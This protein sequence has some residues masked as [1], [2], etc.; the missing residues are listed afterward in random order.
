MSVS[1]TRASGSVGVGLS[2][3]TR[4]AFDG[5]SSE[6][7][8][9][10]VTVSD[11]NV[12]VVTASP[13]YPGDAGVS[14]VQ[15]LAN[16]L[17]GANPGSSYSF[18]VNSA[19]ELEVQ[20][21]GAATSVISI[22]AR[23]TTT[24][25][26]G[27]SY[28]S[29]VEATTLSLTGPANTGDQWSLYLDTAATH[30]TTA[31]SLASIRESFIG[32]ANAHANYRAFEGSAEGVLHL[33]RTSGTP[34]VDVAVA[35]GSGHLAGALV[36][37]EP[38]RHWSYVLALQSVGDNAE[39]GPV[40]LS[41]DT[42]TLTYDGASL[43]GAASSEGIDLNEPLQ[44]IVSQFPGG[45]SSRVGDDNLS[46]VVS[47]DAGDAITFGQV[48]QL[49][50]WVEAQSAASRA[51]SLVG[52][53]GPFYLTAAF[54]LEG[55]VSPGEPWQLEIDGTSY[56]YSIAVGGSLSGDYT[57]ENIARGLANRIN[58]DSASPYTASAVGIEIR[59]NSA[60]DINYPNLNPFQ[61]N[62]ERGDGTSR[63]VFDLD[64]VNQVRGGI[65]FTVSQ[66][67]DRVEYTAR[68]ELHLFLKNVDG[69]LTSI[70]TE[71]L[72]AGSRDPGSLNAEDPIFAYNFGDDGN[73][74]AGTYILRVSTYRDFDDRSLRGSAAFPFSDGVYNGVEDGMSYDL[75]ISA[76]SH[77]QAS[78]TLDLVGTEL[79]YERADGEV[80]TA[81]I[82]S[83][84]ATN[85]IFVLNDQNGNEPLHDPAAIISAL[86][87]RDEFA[88]FAD[89]LGV[90]PVL[91]DSY[92]MVLTGAPEGDETVTITIDPERTRTL[93]SD[94]AFNAL[95]YFGEQYEEQVEVA[96]TRAVVS[97]LG[98]E[99]FEGSDFDFSTNLTLTLTPRG[100]T[101]PA[102]TVQGESWESFI[103]ALSN[104]SL[105]EEL[106]DQGATVGYFYRTSASAAEI[107]IT[108]SS[109]FFL[110]VESATTEVGTPVSG[111]TVEVELTGQTDLGQI[112]NL[113]LD[114][115]TTLRYEIVNAASAGGPI[116]EWV[117]D[118]AGV[119]SYTATSN[120]NPRITD[121][122]EAF[123]N[124]IDQD[125]DLPYTAER[126]GRILRISPAAS[127]GEVSVALSSSGGSAVAGGEVRP[128]TAEVRHQIEFTAANWNVAQTVWVRAVD[129]EYIDGGDRLV[130]APLEERV[131]SVRGPITVNGGFGGNDERFLTNPVLLE[132][133]TN[134]PVA[135]GLIQTLGREYDA[136]AGIY[137]A[138]IS[139]INATHINPS[140]GLRPGFDPRMN[141]FAY[142]VEF[143]EGVAEGT[144]LEVFSVSQ[145]ILSIG[146]A[147]PFAVDLQLA[148]ISL[149]DE[150]DLLV[151]AANVNTV[152]TNSP[153][154]S[155][156]FYT[157]TGL[158]ENSETWTVT[159]Q[160][161]SGPEQFSVTTVAVDSDDDG[162]PDPFERRII[163]SNLVDGIS[164]LD[165]VTRATDF[166][167]DGLTDLQE[168]LLG[169]DPLV[170]GPVDSDDDGIPDPFEQRI[171]DSNA[172]DGISSLDQVTGAT[173]FDSDG[174]TDLQE[175]R[176]GTDP[177]VED[178]DVVAGEEFVA[179]DSDDDGIPDPFEQRII[180]SNRSDG[181][182]SLDQ[183]TGA[184]D[185]D[186]DGLT[187]LQEYRL[188]TDPLVEDPDSEEDLPLST[189]GRVV[190]DLADQIDSH[191]DFAA[192][193]RIGLLG[194]VTLII[195][196]S[197]DSGESLQVTLDTNSLTAGRLNEVVTQGGFIES[198]G[199]SLG[200]TPWTMAAIFL[201]EIGAVNSSW[202]FSVTGGPIDGTFSHPVDDNES[203]ATVLQGLVRRMESL[204][205]VVDGSTATFA[206]EFRPS[207]TG[208]TVTFSE[209]WVVATETGLTLRPL[210]GEAYYYAPFN[211][212]LAVDELDQV[213]VLNVYNGDSPSDDRAILT[214]NRLTGL[215]MGPDTV[216]AG[217]AFSGGIGFEAMEEVNLDLGSGNDTLTVE[218]TP[219][220]LVT[221]GAGA[222]NDL[223]MLENA[224]ANIQIFGETDDDIILVGS[225]SLDSDGDGLLDAWELSWD[226]ISSLGDLS[227]DG[228]FDGDGSTDLQAFNARLNPT[229]AN[230]SGNV[231][232]MTSIEGLASNIGGGVSVDA[233]EGNDS[234][235]F[236]NS[237]ES[238]QQRGTITENSVSGFGLGS[239]Y[240]E[241]VI[242]THQVFSVDASEGEFSFTL[243]GES[244]VPLSFDASAQDVANAL[245][246]ILNPNNSDNAKPHT[247]NF[248]VEELG[249]EYHI[250]FRGE[251]LGLSINPVDVD[252]SALEGTMNFRVLEPVL[253]YYGVETL[254]LSLGSGDDIV[255]VQGTS[256][257]TNLQLNGG[258]DEI[259][260]SSEFD[261]S[262]E[263]RAVPYIGSLDRLAGALNIDAGEGTHQI[264]ISDAGSLLDDP[265]ILITDILPFRSGPTVNLVGAQA[266]ADMFVLGIAPAPITL[267]TSAAGN[268]DEGIRIET[269]SGDDHVYISSNDWSGAGSGGAEGCSGASAALGADLIT[270]L[271]NDTV[272][273]ELSSDCDEALR[274][275]TQ[276]TFTHRMLVRPEVDLAG[277]TNP[278]D[279][280]GLLVAGERLDQ[281]LYRVNP[282][283]N[284]IDM[285]LGDDVLGTALVTA[286]VRKAT[287]GRLEVA[288]GISN[289]E[290]DYD[291]AQEE[292][293]ALFSSETLLTENVDYFVTGDP[294]EADTIEI[295]FSLRFNL[296]ENTDITWEVSEVLTQAVP[297][298]ALRSADRDQ[299]DA[300]RA[301]MS[302]EIRTGV[303]A[304][305]VKGGAGDDH[306]WTGS[307][308]D[309]VFGGAGSDFIDATDS[310]GGSDDP[311]IVF[312]DG[313]YAQLQTLRLV[314]GVPV[315]EDVV[316][317][318]RIF[319][320][321]ALPIENF[322]FLNRL[323]GHPLEVGGGD[324]ILVG[325]GDNF[326]MG[327]PGNDNIE[328]GDG[329][330]TLIGDTGEVG[331]QNSRILTI[332]SIPS[333][334][335][336]EAN[337]IITAGDGANWILGGL[338]SDTITVG[339]D[340]NFLMGDLGSLFFEFDFAS[341]LNRLTRME[342]RYPSLGAGDSISA[343]SGFNYVVTGVGLDSGVI[344]GSGYLIVQGGVMNF[345]AGEIVQSQVI[346]ILS[347]VN[348]SE[349]PFEF[350]DGVA[351]E[352]IPIVLDLFTGAISDPDS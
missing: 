230:V 92:E 126:F 292:V 13:A 263:D 173:D 51:T 301:S 135:D 326:V 273:V 130:F 115:T 336:P 212:N 75:I 15:V 217:R 110:S 334:T 330:N 95:E 327:G 223:I 285:I 172:A 164:S 275:N 38:E 246:P 104:E 32:A 157:F 245:D 21:D 241:G 149:P 6:S 82:E 211:A 87:A 153:E 247:N 210:V 265:E 340:D 238:A 116:D 101:E 25:T 196:P 201:N 54:E 113:V 200:E 239:G 53:E 213:D 11:S 347:D 310:A 29:E 284:S 86:A 77:L 344:E 88:L 56:S 64:R 290:I 47:R 63:H 208:R 192:E 103:Q 175:Y 40:A 98:R 137:R 255:N 22:E 322:G 85:K 45:F 278:I 318:S 93:N 74:G 50:Q 269:G 166:D 171:I 195:S 218:S 121:V 260:V 315:V 42:W 184:T 294:V 214:S 317:D 205:D 127:G 44:S 28:E 59:V 125:A 296:F 311:D 302:L 94:E 60:G 31:G 349:P 215:G 303:D 233:G 9:W 299:V 291:L 4:A 237:I 16:A 335:N 109:P 309:L 96:T 128:I 66:I 244:T 332:R 216:I 160:G 124:K 69:S 258:D 27:E 222:G 163:D 118:S 259:F 65:D 150:A 174:L 337:D 325:G 346:Q 57:L 276:G 345:S 14:V 111:A 134:E 270:G 324:T 280:V 271:G 251:H 189:L 254:N 348:N 144:I 36:E 117:L 41:G 209:D 188:G 132:G 343:G 306:I 342:T 168:Y 102:F 261:V 143:L 328:A 232:W 83:Y 159:L 304:D 206:D 242:E 333:P 225:S 112:W 10:S 70:V 186:S 283:G 26:S 84:D 250:Y 97:F 352:F 61:I 139:D 148:G 199:D 295:A 236:A 288:G 224:S 133:E 43:S 281:N 339:S 253:T 185:F 76:V 190:F 108:G 351:V 191:A 67:A 138:M 2:R 204:E 187:D 207:I 320:R 120:R 156:V 7:G 312:G 72:F 338:G 37:G 279:Q 321:G 17:E 194:E 46:L 268:F 234:V 277:L 152:L 272:L 48:V 71:E 203:L 227:G 35:F 62:A 289:Y 256:A 147:T 20:R 141:E 151:T 114:D 18:S 308:P 198:F 81:T 221:I 90:S 248:R 287:L 293:L 331:L 252:D 267:S 350:L 129:D 24:M 183:V 52:A 282:E 58:A 107:T 79:R 176:L 49:R 257:I 161:D 12:E 105:I 179:V 202:D 170:E 329:S 23:L 8:D 165:Q 316:I 341:G 140:T 169:T 193:V 182:S 39:N 235:H 262:F 154:W 89:F 219:T 307:G 240:L 123:F 300:S 68:P 30:T 73:E 122:A 197:G 100:A 181:I 33:V 298:S 228:D 55:T 249:G 155:S 264:R 313:G 167:S 266:T 286:E 158:F 226:G 80:L 178:P 19:G 78:N 162:I 146:S 142:T 231:E 91:E 305:L 323:Y 5:F 145:D 34:E 314:S 177:L 229:N 119:Y 180:G 297:V 220:G 3:V 99:N 131:N 1:V 319:G 136:E 106:S 274:I 243:L